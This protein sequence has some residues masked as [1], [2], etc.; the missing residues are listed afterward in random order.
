VASAR[1]PQ[2]TIVP[3]RERKRARQQAERAA[4]QATAPS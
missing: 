4:R 1:D 2:Y 3:Q